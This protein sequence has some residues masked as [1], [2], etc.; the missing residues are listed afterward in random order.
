MRFEVVS[1]PLEERVSNTITTQARVALLAVRH[2]LGVLD[3][4]RSSTLLQATH[5][6]NDDKFVHHLAT[7]T[8]RLLLPTSLP[9]FLLLLALLLHVAHFVCLRVLARK[10]VTVEGV[11]AVKKAA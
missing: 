5:L 1:A 6:I 10:I 7:T 8:T 4:Q 9:G 11:A 3:A 2:G